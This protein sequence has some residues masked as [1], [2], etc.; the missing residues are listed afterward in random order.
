MDLDPQG[1]QKSFERFKKLVLAYS[2]HS[3]TTLH[4]GLVGVW[5][6]YKPK[7]R[8]LALARLDPASWQH[9]SIGQGQILR[10]AID[11]IEIQD[12]RPG[13]LTNN[14][15]FWQNR[16]GHM[17]REHRALLDAQQSVGARRAIE[18]ALF[19]LYRTDHN[20]ADLFDRI[21]GLTGQK[22]TLSAYLYFLRD[23][24][25]FMPIQPTGFDEIFGALGIDLTTIR[26]C[27][28]ENYAR[29]NDALQGVR[30][31]LEAVGQKNLSLVDAH[32][33]CWAFR[34]LIKRVPED[35]SGKVVKSGRDDGR[36]LGALERSITTMR[37][38][39]LQTVAQS[40]GQSVTRSVQMKLK[41]FGF[42]SHQALEAYLRERMRI[43]DG[44]CALTGIRFH[45][46]GD[47]EVDKNLLPSPDRIDSDGHYA[48]GNIQIVCQFINMWKSN[49]RNEEFIRLLSLVRGQGQPDG[50]EQPLSEA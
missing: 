3:F 40:R 37:F 45:L 6:S 28:W 30:R 39:I 36:R 2:G 23:S 19:D 21:S 26:Q 14:L 42:E 1:F 48:P 20:P 29:F 8:E 10:R 34:T 7:L 22:Y 4:E 9:T 17:N 16:F 49:T 13:G 44:R 41:D 18:A 24:Q 15:V 47:G 25:R 5:E 12:N 46:H 43:Q 35:G 27:N 32:S 11:A 38:S 33:F 50:V 31:A